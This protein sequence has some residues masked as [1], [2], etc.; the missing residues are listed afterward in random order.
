MA[1]QFEIDCLARSTQWEGFCNP[2][3]IISY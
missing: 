1:L 2:I 3:Y